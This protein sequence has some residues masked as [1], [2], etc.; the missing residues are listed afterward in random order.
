MWIKWICLLVIRTIQNAIRHEASAGV[1][2]N[3]T[4]TKSRPL[5]CNSLFDRLDVLQFVLSLG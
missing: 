3:T 2:G 4:N 5:G 1:G